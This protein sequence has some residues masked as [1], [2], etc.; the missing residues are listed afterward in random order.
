MDKVSRIFLSY[1]AQCEPSVIVS[2]CMHPS[3]SFPSNHDLAIEVLFPQSLQLLRPPRPPK[4]P[5][6]LPLHL[7]KFELRLLLVTTNTVSVCLFS[8]DNISIVLYKSM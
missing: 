6:P 2:L 1:M 7:L 3:L 8:H 5:H 4:P